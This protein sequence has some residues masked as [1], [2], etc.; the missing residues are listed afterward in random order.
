MLA[1][2]SQPPAP[3]DSTTLLE[4]LPVGVATV[5]PD[6]L[7]L[8][9]NLTFA[10]LL[11]IDREQSTGLRIDHVLGVDG[12]ALDAALADC[13]IMGEADLPAVTTSDGVTLLLQLTAIFADSTGRM[14]LTATADPR[15]DL[16]PLL[17][18]RSLDVHGHHK[19][20]LRA[21]PTLVRQLGN[22]V[23]SAAV[24]RA[25]SGWV[26]PHH[27]G[28]WSP[29]TELQSM[30]AHDVPTATLEV[31]PSVPQACTSP[32]HE[33]QALVGVLLAN[34]APCTS[35]SRVEVAFDDHSACMTV[36]ME[37]AENLEAREELELIAEALHAKIVSDGRA[38]G[39]RFVAPVARDSDRFTAPEHPESDFIQSNTVLLVEDDPVAGLVAT[40][41]LERL[42]LQVELVQSG[43]EAI[44]RTQTTAYRW[45]I[46]DCLLPDM[47]GREVYDHLQQLPLR[48]QPS[49]IVATSGMMNGRLPGGMD[50]VRLDG[51]LPKP[52]SARA[53]REVLGPWLGTDPVET[54]AESPA[55][56]PK[57][58]RD[59]RALNGGDALVDQVLQEFLG[60]L[61]AAHTDL[62]AALGELD[63]RSIARTAHRVKGAAATVGA[64]KV[65]AR[66]AA[67][68]EAAAGKDMAAV[69]HGIALLVG[70]T[71]GVELALAD[72]YM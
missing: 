45:V 55:L 24:A 68:Q 51:V 52:L 46:L 44:A 15:A 65:E 1:P 67:L 17:L 70:D 54:E 9:T 33:M 62:T 14:V 48:L 19:P 29:R 25:L 36:V 11:N 8:S 30:V 18:R 57:T 39:V 2:C 38:L 61:S 72:L 22:G 10:R 41:H 3:L 59:I 50:E 27:R 71:R 13:N 28:P 43:G 42:G 64:S 6:G 69:A 31:R 5:G 49:R 60:D 56:D 32:V 66:C 4:A 21:L 40:G 34:H 53:V 26:N 63:F 23:P 7:I 58:I 37:P 47:D 35:D 20:L 16:R 12:G